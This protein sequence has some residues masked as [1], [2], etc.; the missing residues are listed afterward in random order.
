VKS[1]AKLTE[2]PLS[3]IEPE[4]WLRTYLEKQARGITGHIEVAGFPFDRPVWSGPARAKDYDNSWWAFEQ[5]G[6][7]VDGAIRCGY[8]LGDQTLIKKALK[9][10]DY[11]FDH[12]VKDVYLGPAYLRDGENIGGNQRG[13]DMR[14][15]HAVFFR[16]VRAFFEFTGDRRVIKRLVRHYLADAYNYGAGADRDI[17]NIETE[18]W[19][20]KVTG[21]K[22]LLRKALA[23]Y[24]RFNAGPV[25]DTSIAEMLSD[26]APSIHGVT[27]NEQAKLAALV[28]IYSGDKRCLRAVTHAYEKVQKH[29]MLVDGV[30]SSAEHFEGKG[31][32]ASHETCDIADFMWSIGYIL[33]A[34]GNPVYADR[35]E[36]AAFNA[37]PGAVK[38]DLKALQYFSCPNQVVAAHNS[39]HNKFMNGLA[40]MSFRPRPGTECCTGEVNRVMPNYCARMWMA[41]PSGGINALLY[42][43]SVIRFHADG[44]GDEVAIKQ[45]TNYPFEETVDFS[46]RC[47]SDIKFT[48]GLRIPGWCRNARVFLNGKPLKITCKPATI[49]KIRRLFRNNDRITLSLPME[50]K[51]TRWPGGGIAIERGPLVYS[52][53]I[54]EKWIVDAKDK[55]QTPDFPAWNL[56]PASDWN[57][58]MEID[59][60]RPLEE[61]V[62]VVRKQIG[63]AP[64]TFEGAPIELRVPARKVRGWKINRS[65][66]RL[67]ELPPW[68]KA[69]QPGP[70]VFTPPL[71]APA[72][73]KKMLVAKSECITLIPY[74]CTHLRVTIFPQV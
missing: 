16:A 49:V 59:P 2:L 52:L 44:K 26:K 66:K 22:R 64:W 15:P 8:L 17:C 51:T 10:I 58:A 35:I 47:R 73:L 3:V 68:V 41:D 39:N 6:Y 4:G 31:P 48:L 37:A 70:F 38:D 53:K 45:E 33:S 61:Q 72:A 13:K 29:H 30:H 1:H 25:Q 46:V 12:P 69:A 34:T 65:A 11:T 27:F 43:P 62:E 24:R 63:S 32:L 57:Y 71:P 14:W 74:G 9:H 28:Y 36:R 54:G 7:W 20:Y 56:E 21:D 55:N 18:L 40:W 42:G 19:L 5:M 60:A 67:Y 23:E 50:L